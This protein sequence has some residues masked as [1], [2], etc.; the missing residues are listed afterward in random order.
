MHELQCLVTHQLSDA[1]YWKPLFSEQH[2]L[3]ICEA[4]EYF[5]S[6]KSWKW[7]CLELKNPQKHI[8]EPTFGVLET[9]TFDARWLYDL[10]QLSS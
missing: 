7:L 4:E 9:R 8:A 2:W 3:E 5:L 6:N 10:Y 1:V